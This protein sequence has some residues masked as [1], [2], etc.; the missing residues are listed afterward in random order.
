M[1]YKGLK[2]DPNLN[3]ADMYKALVFAISALAILYAWKHKVTSR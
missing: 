1:E 2:K 3:Q